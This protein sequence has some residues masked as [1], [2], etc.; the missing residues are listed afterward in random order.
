MFSLGVTLYQML[1]AELPFNGE[2]MANLIYN[3]ANEKH[4][5]IRRFRPELPACMVT[6]INKSLGKEA[7]QRYQSGKQMAA[8]MKR[9]HEQVKDILA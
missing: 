7:E 5:D 4:P 3:I 8:T 2:T 6:I 9:C 1:T